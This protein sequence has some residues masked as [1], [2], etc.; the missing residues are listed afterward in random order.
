MR[1]R[2]RWTGSTA[3]S[4]AAA[5]AALA[6]TPSPV[7]AGFVLTVVPGASSGELSSYVAYAY[8]SATSVTPASEGPNVQDTGTFINGM[9]ATIDTP[10]TGTAGALVI[11]LN[12]DIDGDGLPDANVVGSSD[13]DFPAMPRPTFGSTLGTFLGLGQE[14]PTQT[15]YLAKA[16]FTTAKRYLAV[17]EGNDTSTRNPSYTSPFTPSYYLPTGSGSNYTTSSGPLDA[18]Y[19]NHS[20]HSLELDELLPL[21]VSYSSSLTT[22]GIPIANVVVPTGTPFTVT[23]S[24]SYSSGGYTQLLA[25][26][27][28]E[29]GV[30][31]PE[32]L[33]ILA[34]GA[35][36]LISR[37]RRK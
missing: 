8:S 13:L 22:L 3:V 9:A 31:E 28:P 19:T 10:G 27:I 29:T 2:N 14:N 30:P 18:D 34:L 11:D 20:V 5:G 37:P 24:L 25:I 35:L 12:D 1:R 4:L 15:G 23:A 17:Y 36:G 21:V 33:G 32:S 6:F 7:R 16:F 26:N